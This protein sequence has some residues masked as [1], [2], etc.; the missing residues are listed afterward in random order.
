[1]PTFH[2]LKA[3]SDDDQDDDEDLSTGRRKDSKRR[4]YDTEYIE[5]MHKKREW[6]K[7]RLRVKKNKTFFFICNII[8]FLLCVEDEFCL[9]I[10]SIRIIDV[11]RVSSCLI[12]HGRLLKTT[13]I[14]Y[15]KALT[16]NYFAFGRFK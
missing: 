8:E 13:M 3:G 11:H 15:G 1:M 12:W 5:K 10:T 2:L 9:N 4:R 6:E 7:K 14:S 16:L